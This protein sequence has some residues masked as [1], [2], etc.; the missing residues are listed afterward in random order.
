MLGFMNQSL[1]EEKQVSIEQEPTHT[2]ILIS[3]ILSIPRNVHLDDI[4]Y[5]MKYWC[6]EK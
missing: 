2:L 4:Y 1:F 5:S 3:L 6:Q